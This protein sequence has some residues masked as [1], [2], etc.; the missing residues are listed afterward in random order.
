VEPAA[1]QCAPEVGVEFEISAAPLVAHRVEEAHKVLLNFRMSSVERKS[2]AMAPSLERHFVGRERL[3]A[4]VLNEPDRV[5]LEEMG[6][7]LGNE[8]SEPDGGFEAALALIAQIV[9]DCCLRR[10]K[11]ERAK[12]EAAIF[13]VVD[14]VNELCHNVATRTE[15]CQAR[16]VSTGEHAAKERSYGS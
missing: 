12:G 1:V 3:A 5:L 13:F 15:R 4:G 9:R 7:A 2:R 6:I 10:G 8:G 14:N 16:L 11:I